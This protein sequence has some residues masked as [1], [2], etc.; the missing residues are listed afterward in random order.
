MKL[1]FIKLFFC[2]LI[3]NADAQIDT[4]QMT[5]ASGRY[6]Y[7]Q[8]GKPIGDKDLTLMFQANPE[9]S[10]LFQQAKSN[11]SAATIFGV[12]GGFL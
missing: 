1:I 2:L 6:K 12:A 9:A 10:K 7:F 4:I 8:N 11:N 3:F 5:K